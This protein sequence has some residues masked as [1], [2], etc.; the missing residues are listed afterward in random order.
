MTRSA[1]LLSPSA[2][3][4]YA[5][6]AA[7]LAAGELRICVPEGREVATS[8]IA[9]V[10]YLTF[11]HP[12][13]TSGGWPDD[14]AEAIA[15]LSATLAVFDLVD[16]PANA[17]Q[18]LLRPV[19]LPRRD[20]LDDDLVT[21]PKYPGKT[22]EQFT[23]L[24]VN[25]TLAAMVRESEPGQ[26]LS[27]LDPLCGRGTTLFTAWLLGHHGYGV[28][29][30]TKAVEQMAAY[31]KTWLRRKR[32]KHTAEVSPVRR[33]GKAIGKRFDAELRLPDRPALNLG[34]FTGDTRTSRE[35]WGRK[36]FD[37]IIT[38]APYG[39][40]HGSSTDVRGVTG[41]RDRSPAGLLGEAVPVWAGQL[42]PGGA[43]GLSWNTHGLSYENLAEVMESAG[44]TVCEGEEWQGFSHRVDSSIQRDLMVAVKL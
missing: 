11:E 22:N 19:E 37:A 21:I 31:L 26:P 42:K 20:W 5:G 27:I 16:D 35:L 34:V 40:V 33:E 6:E 3:R 18:P 23:R 13:A 30:D 9:G 41:K 44:L 36:T 12:D 39:V 25:V 24:L 15:G 32:L 7:A 8:T 1:L 2:N 4:V 43:L 17:D 28:E 14:L 10:D 29:G 38:D